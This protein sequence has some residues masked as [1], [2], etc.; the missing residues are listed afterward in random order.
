MSYHGSSPQLGGRA[1]GPPTDQIQQVRGH[2][3][4]GVIGGRSAHH[5]LLLLPNLVPPAEGHGA[6]AHLGGGPWRLA[7]LGPEMVGTVVAVGGGH[8]ETSPAFRVS[9][10][11]HNRVLF[12][13]RPYWW[14]NETQFYGAG[15]APAL[16]QFPI[17][18][19]TGP[20]TIQDRRDSS[21]TV[22]QQPG[23]CLCVSRILSGVF[24]RFTE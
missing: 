3:Q 14:V 13:E 4:R 5:V 17:T 1:G 9:W 16:Q 11:L 21:G 24:G 8:R 7:Q 10:C 19:E 22:N 6:Q 15:P 23:S 2:I 12:G 20:G 18:C